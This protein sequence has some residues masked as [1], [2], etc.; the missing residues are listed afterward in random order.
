MMRQGNLPIFSNTSY[1]S[2]SDMVPVVVVFRLGDLYLLFKDRDSQGHERMLCP[3]V[4]VVVCR[5]VVGIKM[6]VHALTE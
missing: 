5:S 3:A 4:W 2:P 6:S 1:F